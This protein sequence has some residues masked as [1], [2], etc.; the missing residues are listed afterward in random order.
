MTHQKNSPIITKD[1]LEALDAVLDSI[2]ALEPLTDKADVKEEVL[3]RMKLMLT[4]IDVL[5]EGLVAHFSKHGMDVKMPADKGLTEA[6]RFREREKLT[7]RIRK[8]ATKK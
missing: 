1:Y 6:E 7:R 3:P 8:Y 5:L 2:N 4:F